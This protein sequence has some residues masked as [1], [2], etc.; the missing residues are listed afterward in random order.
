MQ[1]EGKVSRYFV[2][3]IDISI[4]DWDKCWFVQRRGETCQVWTQVYY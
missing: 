4:I 2:P 3:E 1:T